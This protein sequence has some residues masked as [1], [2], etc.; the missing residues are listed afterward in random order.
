MRNAAKASCEI[1]AKQWM[2][3]YTSVYETS[4]SHTVPEQ[5]GA[6]FACSALLAVYG[7]LLSFKLEV[8]FT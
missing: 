8:F 3:Y 2:K 6:Y 5:K 1:D 4:E 7:S